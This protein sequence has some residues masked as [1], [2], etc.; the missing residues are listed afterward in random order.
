MMFKCIT[1]PYHEWAALKKIAKNNGR[2]L[3][4]QFSAILKFYQNAKKGK[5]NVS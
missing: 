1:V 5:R 4:D 3:R 2:T